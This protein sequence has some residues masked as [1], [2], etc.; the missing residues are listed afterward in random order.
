MKNQFWKSKK[1]NQTLKK[2]VKVSKNEMNTLKDLTKVVKKTMMTI[3]SPIIRRIDSRIDK[4]IDIKGMT[5]MKVLTEVIDVLEDIGTNLIRSIHN[6]ISE[7]STSMTYF[8][9]K[10]SWKKKSRL[11]NSKFFFS[12]TIKVQ[13]NKKKKRVMTKSR[14]TSE[15]LICK[16]WANFP[17]MEQ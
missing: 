14:Q 2:I 3:T 16:W 4:V 6:P 17:I 11:L 1:S 12:L 5:I 10:L 9:T 13:N 8:S 7:N 15:I